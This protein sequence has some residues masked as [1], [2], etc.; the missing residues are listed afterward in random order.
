MLHTLTQIPLLRIARPS[1]S[2][3]VQLCPPTS[4]SLHHQARDINHRHHQPASRRQQHDYPAGDHHPRGD[5]PQPQPPPPIS[6]V[7]DAEVSHFSRLSALWWDE[8]GEFALLHKMN[9][10]RIR[11]IREKVLEVSQTQPDST[12]TATSASSTPIPP[13]VESPR[14]LEGMDV[15]DVGCG[16]GI[17]SEV[18]FFSLFRDSHTYWNLRVSHVSEPTRS[19]STH[20]WKTLAS[21]RA[22]QLRTRVSLAPLQ[23]HRRRPRQRQRCRSGMRRLRRSYRSRSGSISYVR[24]R[25][26][27]TSITRRRS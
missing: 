27:S 15:L 10:H 2:T 14:V 11:F 12:A 19:P 24:W 7:N 1:H 6:T 16:G 9:P 3:L 23:Q 20:R 4:A 8:R 5:Q 26:S 25:S 21:R 22:T 18:R 17:L 13:S